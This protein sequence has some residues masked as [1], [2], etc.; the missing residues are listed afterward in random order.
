[1][2][3]SLMNGLRGV[4]STIF[5]LFGNGGETVSTQAVLACLC[6]L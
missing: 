3:S 1:M 2:G 4:V 6:K 5:A